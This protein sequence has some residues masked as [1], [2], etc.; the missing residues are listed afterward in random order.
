MA[1][2]SRSLALLALMF[3]ALPALSGVL[4]WQ[5]SSAED[6]NGN[7]LTFSYATVRM[8]DSSMEPGVDAETGMLNAFDTDGNQVS[9]YVMSSGGNSTVAIYSGPISNPDDL[10]KS[11]LV[12]LWNES[13]SLVGWQMYAYDDVD[14]YIWSADALASVGTVLPA[15]FNS[16]TAAVPEPS[17]G[18]LL[19]IGAGLLALRRNGRAHVLK[20]SARE[21][22]SVV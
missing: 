2:I 16:F 5:V 21:G 4:Y 10:S 17:S 12:E 7:A 22:E 18:L 9:P 8:G 14:S 13:D 15:T 19:I 11:F 3:A 6:E 1:T 20:T